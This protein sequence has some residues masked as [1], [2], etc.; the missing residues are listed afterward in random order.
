MCNVIPNSHQPM[1]LAMHGDSAFYCA[2]QY[3]Q[4]IAVRSNLLEN[5]AIFASVSVILEPYTYITVAKSIQASVCK[6]I[7]VDVSERSDQYV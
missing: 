7:K 4:D 3:N 1:K 2:W 5:P 6:V